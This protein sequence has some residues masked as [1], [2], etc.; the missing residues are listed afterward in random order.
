MRSKQVRIA[1]NSE[2]YC[3]EINH[4]S[5]IIMHAI[6]EGVVISPPGMVSVCS[7]GQLELTCIVPGTFLEWNFFLVPEGETMA[8]RHHRT[9][10]SVSFP[11]TQIWK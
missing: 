3:L 2:L 4:T 9:L 7:G 11:A 1:I 5:P 6:L 10:N 8:R